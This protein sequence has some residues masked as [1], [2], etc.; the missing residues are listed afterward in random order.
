MIY[1]NYRVGC[2]LLHIKA[3]LTSKENKSRAIKDDYNNTYKLERTE[4]PW[5]RFMGGS[6]FDLWRCS[7]LSHPG[8]DM[9]YPVSIMRRSKRGFCLI[10]LTYSE[11]IKKTT[12]VAAGEHWIDEWIGLWDL[13]G[14]GMI[15]NTYDYTFWWPAV[16]NL[17]C[18]Y[19]WGDMG[20][21]PWL[22]DP[23]MRHNHPV[24]SII[25]WQEDFLVA[26]QH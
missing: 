11:E 4:V 3:K 9:F 18:M 5:G 25:P 16:K 2:H 19:I 7:D 24:W 20:L 10:S 6:E 12:P 8:R 26:K 22:E 17:P 21:T 23:W 13:V 15:T 1:K 14:L